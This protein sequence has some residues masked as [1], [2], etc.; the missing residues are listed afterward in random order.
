MMVLFF[1]FLLF[2]ALILLRVPVAIALILAAL[3]GIVAEGMAL[4]N[5]VTQIYRGLDHFTLLAV[6]LFLTVGFLATAGSTGQRLME[7]AVL[8]VGRLRGAAGHVNVVVSML[9]AGI[10]GSATADTAGVGAVLIP[11][12]RKRGYPAPYSAALT[13][14]SSVIGAII[15]PS[16][17]FILYGAFAGT[18]VGALFLAGIIPGTMCG[19]SYMASNYVVARRHDVDYGSDDVLL[20]E[21]DESHGG[22]GVA[23][24]AGPS[25]GAA[26][27]TTVRTEAPPIS[28]SFKLW[29]KLRIGVSAM[30]ALAVPLIIILGITQGFFTPTEAGAAALIFLLA[31]SLFLYRDISVKGVGQ[32]FR[33]SVAFYSLPVL[34]AGAATLFGWVITLLGAQAA[35]RDFIDS[36][37]VSAIGFMALAFFVFLAVGT[38]LDAFPAIVIFAPL[39]LAGAEELGI[40]PVLFGVIVVMTLALGLVT[41]PYGLCLLIASRLADVSPTAAVRALMPLWLITTAII[42]IIIV[43]DDLALAIPRAVYPDQFP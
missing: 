9:F 41:P 27:G 5:V 31:I 4:V 40:H 6:P 25:A 13:A 11:M 39:F 1:V 16:I 18:S 22:R 42:F 12:M 43:F 15:P 23:G 21:T 3:L 14:M 38:F 35:M 10:S 20:A 7:L 26:V 2:I 29:H 32:V 19:L 17:L 24:P 37:E 28:R 8:L 33:D 34:A 36:F 30:P